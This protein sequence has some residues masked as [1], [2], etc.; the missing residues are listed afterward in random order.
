[1]ICRTMDATFINE[2]ANHPEVRPFLGGEGP[3][4]FTLFA[5]TP[6]NLVIE[7]DGG[8]WLLQPVWPGVYELHTLFLPIGRGKAFFAQIKEMFRFVF[9]TTDATEIVTKCPDNNPAARMA[10]T[11]VGFRERFRRENAWESGVGISYM[12]LTIDDWAL[13]DTEAIKAGEEFHDVLEAAKVAKGSDRPIHDDDQTHD[14]FAGAAWLI[15]NAGQPDKAVAFYNRWAIFAG[16]A[17]IAHV[18]HGA[19][20]VQDAVIQ[21]I[22]GRTVILACR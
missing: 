11:L 16:Y 12:A 20:D 4:D 14:R 21:T 5:Q 15:L 18:G 1:M 22:Q 10:A 2:V 8:G 13:R 6:Q 7:A 19:V 9:T 3:L 17:T